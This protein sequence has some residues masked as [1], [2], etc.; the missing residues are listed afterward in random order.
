[1][2][3]LREENI[4]PTEASFRYT[5]GIQGHNGLCQRLFHGHRSRIEIFVGDERRPDLEHY[6][7]REVF[8]SSIHI[9]SLNQI[10]AGQGEVGRRGST[11]EPITLHYA[12]TLG[13]YEATLPANRVFFV[14]SE[15]SV[16]SIAREIARVIKREENCTAPIKVIS[17]EGIDKGA[18]AIISN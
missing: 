14:E 7:A 15:T 1:M 4:S 3:K 8:G 5:H 9:A 6:I 18:I 11:N 2:V 17:Y 16:E 10:K 13:L 12:G